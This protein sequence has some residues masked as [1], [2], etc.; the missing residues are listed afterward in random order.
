MMP[1]SMKL[2]NRYMSGSTGSEL[3]SVGLL[4]RAFSLEE[5]EIRD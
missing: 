5:Q 4:S 2:C 3:G 1:R